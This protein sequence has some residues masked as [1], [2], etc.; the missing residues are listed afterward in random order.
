EDN[1]AGPADLLGRTNEILQQ[2]KKRNWRRMMTAQAVDI[3][4]KTGKFVIAS[5]GHC[6]PYIVGENGSSAVAL[7]ITGMPLGSAS[8]KA[9]SEVLGEIGPGDTIIFY[10]DGII[11]A[12][13]TTGEMLGY[14][15]FEKLL[16]TAWSSDLEEYWKNIMAGYN[17]WAVS[18]D[19]DLTFLMLRRSG[20]SR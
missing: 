4:C 19:D 6:Y 20:G 16:Q 14:P 3:D 2:L 10:T 18:Q 8:K 15:R 17:R 9:H 5:A 11:E 1:Y 12:V 13:D 7:Q